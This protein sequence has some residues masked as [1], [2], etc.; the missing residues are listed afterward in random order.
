MMQIGSRPEDISLA[1][2]NVI[3]AWGKLC[4][5]NANLEEAKVVAP[6]RS[7]V[8]VVAVRHHVPSLAGVHQFPLD[9]RLVNRVADQRPA[10]LIRG[11]FG[12]ANR[13]GQKSSSQEQVGSGH[14]S[15]VQWNCA[16]TGSA[17]VL[18]LG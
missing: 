14:G 10:L 17:T 7:M 3:E 13:S 12:G 9:R 2:A 11:L 16:R 4:E 18:R 5:I 8:E 15:P 6:E 1:E